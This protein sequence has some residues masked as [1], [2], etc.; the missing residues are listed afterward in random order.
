MREQIDASVAALPRAAIALAGRVP[1]KVS[2]EN[3]PIQVGDLLTTSNVAGHAMKYVPGT[4][5][6]EGTVIG[7][8]LTSSADGSG[9]VLVLVGNF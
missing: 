5:G 2:L 9:T 3:G 6:A 4:P 7:K 8:A 1:V